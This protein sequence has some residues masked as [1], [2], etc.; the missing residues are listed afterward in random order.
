MQ[1]IQTGTKQQERYKVWALGMLAGI[2][3]AGAAV[4]DAK[5][6]PDP[7]PVW[8]TVPLTKTGA[9]VCPDGLPYIVAVNDEW[10]QCS[11]AEV[12]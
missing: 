8:E 12:R 10:V 5:A 1:R 7:L 6:H 2:A 4:W 3:L 9:A 11:S